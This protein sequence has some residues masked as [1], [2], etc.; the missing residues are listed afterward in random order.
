MITDT[1]ASL[2]TAEWEALRD[3]TGNLYYNV[4]VEQYAPEWESHDTVGGRD[5]STC[6]D[7]TVCNDTLIRATGTTDTITIDTL[8]SEDAG[9]Q[10]WSTQDITAT[11]ID[12]SISVSLVVSGNTAR[13]FFYNGSVILYCESADKGSTWGA[14]TIALA[15]SDVEHISATGLTTCHYIKETSQGNHQLG[16][17]IYSGGWS[18]SESHIKYPLPIGTMDAISFNGEDVIVVAADLPPL[19]GHAI[20]GT[21]LVWEIN[22]VSGLLIFIYANGKWSDHRHFDVLDRFGDRRRNYPRLS[23]YDDLLFLTYWVKEG[24][25][26]THEAIVTSRCKSGLAFELPAQMND[27]TLQEP[28][29]FLKRGDH[30]YLV[31]AITTQRSDSVAFCGD[32]QVSED[33]SSYVSGIT[34]S[35]AQSKSTQYRIQN[36]DDVLRGPGKLLGSDYAQQIRLTLG[37]YYGSGVDVSTLS[38]QVTLSDIYVVE[39]DKRLPKIMLGVTTADRLA[40]LNA[41][42]SPNANEWPSQAIGADHYIDPTGTGYGGLSHTAPQV[43]SFETTNEELRLRSSNAEGVAWS[44]FC[45][46]MFNGS[47]SLAIKLHYDDKNEYAGVVFWG[48]DKDNLWYVTY[49]PD[50]DALYLVERQDGEDTIYDTVFPMGWEVDTWYWI[51]VVLNYARIL[52]YTATA[53]NEWI[54]KI[55]YERAVIRASEYLGLTG[56]PLTSGWAG[57][58]GW[59]YSPSTSYEPPTTP[60]TGSDEIVFVGTDGGGIYRQ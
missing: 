16:C 17:I 41:I 51:K 47:I 58:I 11:G 21:T 2:T 29:I 40:L 37:Y 43:G 13:V 1:E 15:V 4:T 22:R 19:L 24:D 55:D 28:V 7:A 46:G 20:S 50:E 25:Y 3:E 39:N 59:G 32:A 34:S 12:T 23:S 48:A 36:P 52:I 54:E 60:V 42:S 53:A 35:M 31:N 30:A 56:L 18:D 9:D 57:P 49:H 27:A 8:A 45:P 38:T 14:A 6:F 10:S 5:H 44:T 33:I 26:N